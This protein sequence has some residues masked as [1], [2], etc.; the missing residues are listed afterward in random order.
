MHPIAY[1]FYFN[2]DF[3]WSAII[4]T[5]RF[6]INRTK[7]SII[8]ESLPINTRKLLLSIPLT[9]TSAAVLGGVILIELVLAASLAE[10]IMAPELAAILV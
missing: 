5:A 9:I 6:G 4:L 10:A 2:S 3:I 7:K 1:F 8:L